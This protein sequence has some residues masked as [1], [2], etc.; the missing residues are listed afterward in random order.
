M[1]K[2]ALER[3]DEIPGIDK[4]AARNVLAEIGTDLPRFPSAGRLAP[5]A[6]LCPGNDQSAGKRRSGRMNDGNR[7]LKA[8]LNPCAWA[9]SRKKDSYF[10]AQHRRIASRRGMKQSRTWAR[11]TST[12]GTTPSGSGG[13]W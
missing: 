5:W 2:T 11:T 13:S 4:R 7:W 9:A 1:E 3:L 10:A 12:A 8:T 6:G